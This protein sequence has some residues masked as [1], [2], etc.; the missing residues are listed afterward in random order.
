LREHECDPEKRRKAEIG[1]SAFKEG[2]AG[3]TISVG[4][5]RSGEEAVTALSQDTIG[6]RSSVSYSPQQ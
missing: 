5:L 1:V 6:A 3:I 2:E 4:V